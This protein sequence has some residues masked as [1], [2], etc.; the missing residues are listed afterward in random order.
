MTEFDELEAMKTIAA[1]LEPLD[2]AARARALQWAT[3]RF[4]TGKALIPD[5]RS[6]PS[7]A[8]PAG[9]TNQY[10]SFA[11]LF[12]AARPSSERDKA[13]VA[14]YWM[15]VCENVGSFP[16]QTLNALLKDLGHRVGN[17]TEAL[18]ALKNEK[19]ALILQLKKSGTSR[20]A[21]KTYKL[22]QEG[23]KRVAGMIDDAA[24]RTETA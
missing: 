12:D 17:I 6:N 5:D 18:T 10:A 21:R 19:P 13:L 3:S 22:S 2:D 16:S 20:Q 4:R 11:D 23:A 24:D 14:A 1:A 8:A 7:E 9:G 15:Q